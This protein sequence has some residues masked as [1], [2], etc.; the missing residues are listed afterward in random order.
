MEK[1][2]TILRYTATLICGLAIGFSTSWKL[3][4]VIMACAPL[5]A[6]SLSILILTAIK[7]EKAERTAYARAG[8]CWTAS[9]AAGSAPRTNR[10]VASA[11]Y[12]GCVQAMSLARSSP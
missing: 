9:A 10:L 5:T 2:P 12:C 8:E 7:S 3:T 1:I 4:L 6:T 11:L